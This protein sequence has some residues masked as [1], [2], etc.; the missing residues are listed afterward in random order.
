MLDTNICIYI[1]KQYPPEV[2]RKLQ[3]TVPDDVVT[4]S[5]I[6]AELQYGISKSQHKQKNTIALNDFLNFCTVLDWPAAAAEKYGD[7]RAQLESQGRI[8]GANDLLI[9]AH[10]LHIDARLITN[11]M[12]EFNRVDGLSVENWLD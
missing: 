5:V 7:I 11:N 1:M 10:A 9:A 6:L 8:I 12:N 2:C 3:E 4:S